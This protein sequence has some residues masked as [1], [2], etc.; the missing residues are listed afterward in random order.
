MTDFDRFVRRL[1]EELRG[2]SDTRQALRTVLSELV[3]QPA[4]VPRK[5]KLHQAE[6]VGVVAGE[7]SG[8]K[9]ECSCGWM[10]PLLLK[11]HADAAE[12]FTLAHK[13]A[14]EHEQGVIE[15]DRP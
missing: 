3:P 10:K 5:M 7:W 13:A 2:G 8:A 6:V 15:E 4:P 9:V 11:D 12:L 14:R 1:D